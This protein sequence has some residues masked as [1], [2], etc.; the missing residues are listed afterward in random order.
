M[1][2]RSELNKESQTKRIE[3]LEKENS[4]VTKQLQETIEE[5]GNL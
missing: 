4:L 2:T 1:P 3:E 5:S